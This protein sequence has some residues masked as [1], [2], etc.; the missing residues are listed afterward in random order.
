[1]FVRERSSPSAILD[2]SLLTISGSHHHE[3]LLQMYSSKKE[4][5]PLI[6]IPQAGS[7]QADEALPVLLSTMP[8]P[9]RGRHPSHSTQVPPLR[10]TCHRRHL[11]GLPAAHVSGTG[12]AGKQVS[13]Q[14]LHGLPAAQHI[15]PEQAQQVSRS[16]DRNLDG[17]PLAHGTVTGPAGNWVYRQN[18]HGLP[19]AH[20]PGTG[21]AGN[22]VH[23]QN[24]HG[25]PTAHGSGTGPAGNLETEPAWTANSTWIRNRSSR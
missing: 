1:V 3:Q 23:R 13:K 18:L 12:P 2:S 20:G 9:Y 5:F 8:R 14:N 22:W 19:P 11:H 6:F 21:P 4:M 25:L 7:I 15:D 10:W 24:L 16:V 17:L